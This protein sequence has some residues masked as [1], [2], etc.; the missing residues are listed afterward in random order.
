MREFKTS[1]GIF[2]LAD[3]GRVVS[4]I[5]EKP[6]LILTDPPYLIGYKPWERN[7]LA[8]HGDMASNQ[9]IVDIVIQYT[10]LLRPD[11]ALYCFC[12]WKSVDLWKSKLEESGIKVKNIIIWKKNNWTAGDLKGQY[13]QQYEMILY[14]PMEKHTLAGR[15]DTD[16]WEFKRVS[17]YRRIHPVEKPVELIE[18][19][20]RKSTNPQDLVIDPFAGSGSVA[21]ACENLKRRWVCVEIDEIIFQKAIKR[22]RRCSYDNPKEHKP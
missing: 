2:Y 8:V 7:F 11:G 14:C 13:S 10:K 9:R 4:E 12:S 20:L 5:K 1:L 21:V 19:I 16:I 6:K 17:P 18:Y 22:I 3:A 15:R